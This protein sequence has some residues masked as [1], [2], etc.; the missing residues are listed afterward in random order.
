M[1]SLFFINNMEC[2]VKHYEEGS[3]LGIK[4]GRI[5]KLAIRRKGRWILNYDRGWDIRPDRNDK[6]LI[7]TYKEIVKKYN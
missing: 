3:R 5:S 4:G 2:Q 1:W 6:E 7:A